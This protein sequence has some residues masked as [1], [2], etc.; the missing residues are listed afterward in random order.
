MAAMSSLSSVLNLLEIIRKVPVS[1]ATFL[2][3]TWKKHLL[4]NL[5]SFY[6]SRFA[7]QKFDRF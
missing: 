6:T 7:M 4:D 5:T 1:L 3:F 2:Q